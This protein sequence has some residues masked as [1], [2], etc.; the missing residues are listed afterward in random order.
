MTLR[1]HNELT[2]TNSRS[3]IY[4]AQE[5]AVFNQN[6]QTLFGIMAGEV[7][8]DR[9][10]MTALFDQNF[11]IAQDVLNE[12][13]IRGLLDL[14]QAY[15]VLFRDNLFEL[16]LMCASLDG[17]GIESQ[18]DD[19]VFEQRGISALETLQRLTLDVTSASD[20]AELLTRL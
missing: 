11:R 5:Y 15:E 18:I 19:L 12:L 6:I 20:N 7:P 1:H 16:E 3:L 8:I 13:E 14:R 4:A 10:V 2:L 9:D 17:A